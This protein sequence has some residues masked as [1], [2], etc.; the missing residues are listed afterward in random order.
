MPSK[1][2]PLDIETFEQALERLVNTHSQE[3]CSDTP[4]FLLARYLVRCLRVWNESVTERETW[5]GRSVKV[6]RAWNDTPA[7]PSAGGTE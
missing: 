2:E 3:N 1:P 4:D 6:L 7:T 5:Y